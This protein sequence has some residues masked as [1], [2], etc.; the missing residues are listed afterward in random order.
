MFGGGSRAPVAITL[1]VKNPNATHEGCNPVPRHWRLSH[2]RGEIG[3]TKRGGIHK[4]YSAIGRRLHLISIM[5]GS[6][7]AAKRLLSFTH[8]DQRTQRQAG[9][10][11]RCLVCIHLGLVTNRDAYIYNFSRDTCAAK[12]QLMT[13]DY[14]AAFSEL[15]E[16]PE[17]T[18]EEVARRHTKIP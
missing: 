10:T 8:S 15:E 11:M 9:R 14:L 16:N 17:L 4:R 3:G 7:N 5:I 6:D 1:L 12:T 2:T 18:V 13:Q